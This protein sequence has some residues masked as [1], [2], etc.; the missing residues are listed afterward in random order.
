MFILGDQGAL[1]LESN[2]ILIVGV[3]GPRVEGLLWLLFLFFFGILA[4]DQPYNV[5]VVF[6]AV[7]VDVGVELVGVFLV[8]NLHLPFLLRPLLLP[9]LQPLFLLDGRPLC[10]QV[11]QIELPTLILLHKLINEERVL[12]VAVADVFEVFFGLDL[13][14]LAGFPALAPL[15][16]E[17]D[18]A[19][20]AQTQQQGAGHHRHN[21]HRD[22]HLRLH[23]NLFERFYQRDLNVRVGDFDV[24]LGVFGFVPDEDE[25]EGHVGVH[26]EAVL[27]ELAGVV[28]VEGA[29]DPF[30]ALAVQIPIFVENRV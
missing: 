24:V 2:A 17:V 11:L 5:G 30:E 15:V 8:Q 28:E 23:H 26:A 21:D 12:V 7:P 22:R 18:E 3:H 9:L 20:E 27:L 13:E 4:V 14:G 10:T 19:E 16:A 1:G 6:A 25:V 29:D